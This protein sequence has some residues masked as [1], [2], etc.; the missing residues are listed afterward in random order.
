MITS[1]NPELRKGQK[2][3]LSNK[4]CLIKL[5]GKQN[6]IYYFEL[7]CFKCVFSCRFS[8]YLTSFVKKDNTN[9]VNNIELVQVCS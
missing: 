1:Y 5:Y 2:F 6:D 7:V 8:V 3:N 4:Q 9:K